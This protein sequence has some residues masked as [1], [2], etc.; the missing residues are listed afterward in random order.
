MLHNPTVVSLSS[1]WY[2]LDE[3]SSKYGPIW[4]IP[5]A[6]N[7][8]A[9]SF[10]AELI[11]LETSELSQKPDFFLLQKFFQS[12]QEVKTEGSSQHMEIRIK[13][14]EASCD[15]YDGS[16]VIDLWLGNTDYFLL[17]T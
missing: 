13:Y 17:T 5:C 15:A 14:P 7:L 12:A 10:Q 8:L 6:Q 9:A 2:S 4:L 16:L 1:V 3:H 11:I